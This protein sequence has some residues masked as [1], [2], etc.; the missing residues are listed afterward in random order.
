MSLALQ[1]LCDEPQSRITHCIIYS[2][3]QA[4]LQATMKP[5]KQSGQQIIKEFL[6]KA[7]HLQTQRSIT[8]SLVWIPGH[9]D[10]NG[11]EAADK[12]AKHAANPSQVQLPQTRPYP[13][14]K[15]ARNA[16]IHQRHNNEWMRNWQTGK[17]NAMQLRRI[18]KTPL[19]ESGIKLY[20]SLKTRRDIATAVRLRTGH[21]GLNNYLHRIG[22]EESPMCP[23]GNGNKETVKHLL[24]KCETYEEE[25]NRLRKQMGNRMLRM[26]ILL[27]DSKAIKLTLEFIKQ[28]KRLEINR[29]H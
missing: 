24:L 3:S 15:A 19:A 12:A 25:R 20:G 22:I 14:M 13:T 5:A 6:D 21:C 11:N 2:D 26:E 27:G 1:I 7:E 8:I 9:M 4:G 23:C 18:C 29:R 16:E 10:I 17:E 28:T